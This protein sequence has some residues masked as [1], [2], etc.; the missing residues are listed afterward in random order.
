MVQRLVVV[1]ARIS[2]LFKNSIVKQHCVHLGPD[3]RMFVDPLISQK[4]ICIYIGQTVG[5]NNLR[6]RLAAR[7]AAKHRETENCQSDPF[8]QE[9]L[10]YLS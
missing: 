9:W 1:L 7:D 3:I 5:R 6:A 2:V 10:I 8:H 4:H